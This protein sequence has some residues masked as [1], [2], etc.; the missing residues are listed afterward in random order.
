VVGFAVN[1]GWFMI[2]AYYEGQEP[3][4]NYDGGG[5]E[6]GGSGGSW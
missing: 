4:P 5:Y 6:Y 1:A 3:D 2:K